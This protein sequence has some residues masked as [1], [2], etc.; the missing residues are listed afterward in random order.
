VPLRASR[1]LCSD[2]KAK[3]PS[4]QP[5]ICRL[6]VARTV[7]QLRVDSLIGYDLASDLLCQRAALVDISTM[8]ISS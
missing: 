1:S 5:W 2:S 8:S 4:I 3:L 7:R 6:I